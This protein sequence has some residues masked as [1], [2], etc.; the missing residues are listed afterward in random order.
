MEWNNWKDSFVEYIRNSDKYW[1][2][3]KERQNLKLVRIKKKLCEKY[4]LNDEEYL[5]FVLYLAEI[6]ETYPKKVYISNIGGS[7]N[8]WMV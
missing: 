2:G 1:G 8:A 4:D 5:D 6:R 7:G 3:P